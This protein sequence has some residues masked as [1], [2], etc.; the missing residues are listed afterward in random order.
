MSRPPARRS[1][2]ARDRYALYEASVQGPGYD[3]DVFERVWRTVR[4]GRFRTLREDFCGT[5]QLACAWA[6]RR[7]ANRALGIDLDARVLEW[8]RAQH[9]A[10]MGRA[11]PRVRLLRRDVRTVTRPVVDVVAALN[12]S[13]WVLKE[14]AE[15]RRYFRA[16]R[17]S[18][19]PRGL[20]F[21]HLFGGTQALDRLVETRRVAPSTGPDGLRIPG[22]TY[23]WEQAA[24]NPVDHRLLSHIHFRFPGKDEMR[25]AFSYD[26]RMWT[27]PE[28]REVL[29]EAGF[30]SSAVYVEGWDHHRHAPDDVFRRRERFANQYGWL[31]YVVGVA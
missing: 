9:V 27:L 4:G 21:M 7:P 31:A 14:R 11:A 13:W 29:A 16:V 26:W 20:F 28:A 19:R 2:L 8:A 10:R 17:R 23:V 5:A 3:L 12:F 24:F 6:E 15:L 25:R 22:F 18:L 1:P 30:R